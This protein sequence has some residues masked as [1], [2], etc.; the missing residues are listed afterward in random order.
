[1]RKQEMM[2]SSA[3]VV[4]LVLGGGIYVQ[5]RTFTITE[6]C[7]QMARYDGGNLAFSSDHFILLSEVGSKVI[8]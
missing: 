2:E 6:F 1:M 7:W 3:Q 5:H 8:N 4:Y